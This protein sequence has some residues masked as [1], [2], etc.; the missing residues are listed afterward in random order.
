[1]SPNGI[2]SIITNLTTDS[3]N[4]T[5]KGIHNKFSLSVESSCGKNSMQSKNHWAQRLGTII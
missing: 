1:M 4:I 2:I 5:F 3:V